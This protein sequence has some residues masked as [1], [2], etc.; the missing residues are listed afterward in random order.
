MHNRHPL[1][2]HLSVTILWANDGSIV[3]QSYKEVIVTPPGEGRDIQGG[4]V[5]F[6]CVSVVPLV[7]QQSLTSVHL[8]VTI[9]WANDGSIGFI[10]LQS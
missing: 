1:S 8:S 7:C 9:L 5:T 4:V 6:V 3:L 10:V 2:V